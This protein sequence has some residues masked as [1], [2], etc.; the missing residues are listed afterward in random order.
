MSASRPAIP[1]IH[2]L[3]APTR[4]GGCDCWSSITRSTLDW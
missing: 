4:I 1:S 3:P 2:R